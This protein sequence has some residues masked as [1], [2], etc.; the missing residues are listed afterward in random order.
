MY[1]GATTAADA[2][3]AVRRAK[4]WSGSIADH[5]APLDLASHLVAL[6]RASPAQG[7]VRFNSP[8]GFEP[9]PFRRR[10][11]PDMTDAEMEELLGHKV[12]RIAWNTFFVAAPAPGKS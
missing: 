1:D 6:Y 8:A 12:Q 3:E 7:T 2:V 10:K 4:M 5:L 11:F 9:T